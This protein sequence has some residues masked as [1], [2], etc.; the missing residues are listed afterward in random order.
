MTL[1]YNRLV[2][3][4]DE[5]FTTLDVEETAIAKDA[6]GKR[7]LETSSANFVQRGYPKSN[8]KTQNKMKKPPKN[9]PM[10]KKANIA[11]N[12]KKKGA[13]YVCGS[14]DHFALVS[15]SQRQQ[16]ICQHGY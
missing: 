13:C 6:R 16:E 4:F 8:P 14:K 1:K 7:V 3:T 15:G 9:P 2:F 11:A 5:L 10:A 12:K